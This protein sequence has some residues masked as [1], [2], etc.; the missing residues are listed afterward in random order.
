MRKPPYPPSAALAWSLGPAAII[1]AF[2]LVSTGAALLIGVA[3]VAA[4]VLQILFPAT[5]H[6][7]WRR[8]YHALGAALAFSML[9]VA[10]SRSIADLPGPIAALA[11]GD[12]GAAMKASSAAYDAERKIRDA[13]T[14]AAKAAARAAKAAKKYQ[15]EEAKRADEARWQAC[16]GAGDGAA[17]YEA[18]EAVRA[19]LK[20]PRGAKFSPVW[21]TTIIA[22]AKCDRR[23]VGSV[24]AT[25]GFGAVIRSRWAVDLAAN[26]AGDWT[27]TAVVIE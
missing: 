25:N 1:G 21:E 17:A 13:E 18:K 7:V 23:V 5:Y 3:V 24:D 20:N 27:V 2:L 15:L 4:S 22:T 8:R 19:Q 9:L 14:A 10:S 11:P 6:G 26:E 16:G 12:Q